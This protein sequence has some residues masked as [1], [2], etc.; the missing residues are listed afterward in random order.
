MKDLEDILHQELKGFFA[1]P[2]KVA[3][4]FKEA[5]QNLA[6]RQALL[7]AHPEEIQKVRDEMARTHRLY[8]NG[9]IT[10]QSF[11]AFYEPAGERLNRL[12]AELP[13]LEAKA[14]LLKVNNHSA[15]DILHEA[16]TLYDR[17]PSLPHEDK[18]KIAGSLVEKIVIGEKEID[19]NFSY[20][21]SCKEVCKNQPEL[22]AG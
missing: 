13:D 12:A 2:G 16:T 8:L 1:K 14:D 20:L 7:L 3:L 6:E 5:I 17:R 22:G 10:S 18:R 9:G 21:P 19:I 4:H 11:G 15:D